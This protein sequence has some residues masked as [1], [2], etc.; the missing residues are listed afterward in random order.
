MHLLNTRFSL[1]KR[2]M[3]ERKKIQEY[4]NKHVHIFPT[5]IHKHLSFKSS[6]I[7]INQLYK[8]SFRCKMSVG[9]AKISW[10]SE[11]NNANFWISYTEISLKSKIVRGV[12]CYL[13]AIHNY[14]NTRQN[15]DSIYL[16]TKTTVQKPGCRRSWHSH[17]GSP[18]GQCRGK[19]FEFSKKSGKRNTEK[20]LLALSYLS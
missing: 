17:Q 4:L 18:G 10:N 12:H 19:V 3:R 14:V 1:V 5:N 13:T 7:D 2:K 11:K 20:L 15:R 8:S 9:S 16:S 6:L